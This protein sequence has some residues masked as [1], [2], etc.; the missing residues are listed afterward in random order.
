MSGLKRF[1][2]VLLLISL[3]APSWV[4]AERLRSLSVDI[5]LADAE[6]IKLSWSTN[7]SLRVSD[8]TVLVQKRAQSPLF[9]TVRTIKGATAGNV[10]IKSSSNLPSEYRLLLRSNGRTIG[11]SAVITVYP[12]TED[13]IVTTINQDQGSGQQTGG[14]GVELRDGES[15]CSQALIESVSTLIG[16]YRNSMGLPSFR[17]NEALSS[18]ALA[19]SLSMARQNLMTHEGWFDEIMAAGYNFSHLAQNIAYGYT[20]AS[21]LVN[22]WLASPGHYANIVSPESTEEGLACIRDARGRFWWSHNMG[23]PRS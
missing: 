4:Y 6:H 5:A 20:D 16:K 23:S 8:S 21:S 13:E 2:P 15:I 11:R 22:A 9:K 12:T 3:F 18:A 17:K 7:G 19:H 1:I 14:R 10:R